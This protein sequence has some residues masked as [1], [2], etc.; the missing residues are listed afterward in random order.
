MVEAMMPETMVVKTIMVE[1]AAIAV[2]TPETPTVKFRNTSA[3]EAAKMP[4]M[5][6]S[7]AKVT[8]A[9]KVASRSASEC[10]GGRDR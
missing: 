5:K 3:V 2:K 1:R 7:T 6:A 10:S 4:A 9:T 8:P